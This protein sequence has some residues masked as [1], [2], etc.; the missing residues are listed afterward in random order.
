MCAIRLD[1]NGIY[2]HIIIRVKVLSGYC[3]CVYIIIYIH[4]VEMHDL[5]VVIKQSWNI[6]LKL[7]VN[8]LQ[9][10]NFYIFT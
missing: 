8:L 2:E 7:E 4:G 9:I 5:S 3:G 6:V 1:G 10:I